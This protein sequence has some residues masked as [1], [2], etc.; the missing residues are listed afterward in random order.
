MNRRRF[1]SKDVYKLKRERTSSSHKV[2]KYLLETNSWSE[3]SWSRL[4]KSELEVANYEKE[5]AK[6]SRDVRMLEQICSR[7]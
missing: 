2:S 7:V 3:S 6:D 1:S 5:R 4:H